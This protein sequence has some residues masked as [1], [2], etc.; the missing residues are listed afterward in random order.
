MKDKRKDPRVAISFPVECNM[1]SQREYFYTVSK[2]LSKGGARIIANNFLPKGNILKL[3]INFI[4][5]TMGIKAEIAWCNKE[6]IGERYQA[7][8]KF[9]ETNENNKRTLEAF[10]NQIYNS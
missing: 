9:V 1:L 3:N 5:Q 2:D 4:E 7:G 8:L 10:L 6:R